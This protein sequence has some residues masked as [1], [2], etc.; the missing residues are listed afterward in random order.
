VFALRR[1]WVLL[2]ALVAANASAQGFDRGLLWRLDKTGVPISYVFG[3][4]HASDARVALVRP[5]LERAI[6][7]VDMV[8]T[9]IRMEYEEM[10][11]A[12][13]GMLLPEGRSLSQILGGGDFQRFAQALGPT[14]MPREVLDRM[15]PFAAY[16][17]LVTPPAEDRPPLDFAIY[18]AGKQASRRMV[19]LETV[20][21][22][23]AAFNK[24]GDQA[25]AAELRAALRAIPAVREHVERMIVLHA[26]EDLAGLYA[27][28]FAPSPWPGSSPKFTER[29]RVLILDER[30]NVMMARAR[31]LLAKQSVLIAVGAAH[32]PGATGLLTQF[33]REG[34]RVTRM[35]LE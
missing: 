34:Y 9:E 16:A 17:L 2:L 15:T 22:Q 10:R 31:P 11:A 18:N 27:I 23:L 35:A 1:W 26:N 25:V 32:L 21:E 4:I 5:G 7:S 12:M 28:A 13:V 14:R 30:N 6:R 20:D 33:A 24:M 19:G 3:T 8:A 29:A